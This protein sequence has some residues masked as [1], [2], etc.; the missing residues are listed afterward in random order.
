MPRPQS[1]NQNHLPDALPNF[2]NLGVALR[3]LLLV[4]GIALL[5]AVAHAG[6]W[7]DVPN[8]LIHIFA[9][10]QPVLLSSLLLLFALNSLLARLDYRQGCATVLALVTAVTLAIVQLGGDLYVPPFE[11]GNF[12]SW[13]YAVLSCAIAAALLVYFGLRAQALSPA[14]YQARLQALQARIRPHFLFNCINSVLGVV[15]NDPKRAE[16]ALEDMADLFRMA[17]AATD[18]LVPLRQEVE[19]SRQYLALEQLRLGERLAIDWHTG[20]MP[21][22]ALIPP[23]LLQP[24]LENAVYHGIEPLAGGGRIDINLYRSGNEMHLEVHNPQQEQ[25]A[26]H[27]GNKMALD[28]IRERL[29]LQFDV[30]AHYAVEAGKGYYRVHIVMPYVKEETR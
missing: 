8:Q 21:D 20:D 15:R 27:P 5:A 16:T 10:L 18:E 6:S 29:A 14:V 12:S 22:D 24:L 28:N 19:L 9:L 13:R 2:R 4:C 26:Q 11:Q 1:I 3:I 7:S 30:E 17:M 25:E 23:L